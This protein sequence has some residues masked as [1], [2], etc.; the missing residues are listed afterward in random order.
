MPHTARPPSA[1]NGD[2]PVCDEPYYEK[3]VSSSCMGSGTSPATGVDDYCTE[4]GRSHYLTVYYI[5]DVPTAGGD[6]D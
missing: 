5:H 6:D 4:A 1:P 2:C 3:K